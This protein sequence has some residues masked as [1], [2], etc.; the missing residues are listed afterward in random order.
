MK[1]YVAMYGA[2]KAQLD[3][4]SKQSASGEQSEDM[5]AWNQWAEK[6]KDAIVDMGAPLGKNKRVT[7]A[8]TEDVSNEMCGYTVVQADSHEDASAIFAD[9]P[10]L[11]YDGTWID[12]LEWVDM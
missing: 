10:H 4:W 5:D 2:T 8:K 3:E 7:S 1:K 6:H 12:V 9:N 11:K